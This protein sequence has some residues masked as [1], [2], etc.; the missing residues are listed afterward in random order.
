MAIANDTAYGLAAYVQGPQELARAVGRRLRAG[1]VN[2]NGPA[3]DVQAPFGG[4]RQ[5]GNGREYA[6]W[7]LHHVCEVKALVGYG[8]AEN[9]SAVSP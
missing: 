5:S 6:D 1:Q 3:W 9:P 2:L 4:Y 7:G 8:A